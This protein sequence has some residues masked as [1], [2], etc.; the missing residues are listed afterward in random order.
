MPAATPA[1]AVIVV[2]YRA[3]RYLPRCLAALAQQRFRDFEVIIVDNASGDGS[4]EAV[5]PLPAGYR[6][7]RLP[8]NLGFA[9]ANNEAAADTAAP[10][11]ATLNPD[12][13][14]EPEWLS[15]LMAATRRHPDVA[16]FGSTQIVADEPEL[17]D[18]VGDVFHISGLTWR[19]GHRRALATCPPEGET[20]SP[21]AAAALY[22]RDAFLAAGGFDARFFCYNEDVDLGFR[23]RLK[24]ERCV[25]VPGAR[26]LHVG[27]AITGAGSAFA[28][29]H[30][31]RNLLW[32]LIKNMPGPLLAI[33]LPLHLGAQALR[34]GLMA[35]RGLARPALNGL[36]DAVRAI[37]PLL[38]ERRRIQAGRRIS[39]VA[40][41]RALAWSPTAPFRAFFGRQARPPGT[42]P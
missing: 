23:L 31:T 8:A 30:S 29:Y 39:V 28:A 10:W 16:L 19:H 38:A 26:V 22:R 3:G 37:G 12:A 41:A 17:L 9:A 33:S 11:L 42:T 27:S 4:L 36:Q 1:V 20:F 34:L 13:F 25:Q 21:C 40:T 5:E 6:A 32:T 15:E 2:N 18:G 14:P 35:T 24:G 7:L